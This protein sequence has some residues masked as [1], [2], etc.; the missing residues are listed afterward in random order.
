MN[1][2]AFLFAIIGAVLNM[3]QPVISTP[4]SGSVFT[5]SM[6]DAFTVIVNYVSKNGLP[7]EDGVVVSMLIFVALCLVPIFVVVQG[8]RILFRKQ[9]YSSIN[10]ILVCA[11]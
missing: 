5:G 8:V 9:Q 10:S 1:V 4:A 6:Y 2:I 11:C 3:F 7:S